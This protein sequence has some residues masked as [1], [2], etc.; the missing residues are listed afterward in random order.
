[1]T[2]HVD[3]HILYSRCPSCKILVAEFIGHLKNDPHLVCASCQRGFSI[4]PDALNQAI[5]EICIGIE[6][7]IRS[8]KFTNH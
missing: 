3:T 6:T 7:G 2:S 4:F 1:M 5:C 8:A